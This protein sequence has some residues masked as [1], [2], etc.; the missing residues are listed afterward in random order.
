M[1][2]GLSCGSIPGRFW[3]DFDFQM[4]L[5]WDPKCSQNGIKHQSKINIGFLFDFWS[6][7]V[8]MVH[9]D[10]AARNINVGGG[11]PPKHLAKFKSDMNMFT[12]TWSLVD[13]LKSDNL[14][15]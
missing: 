11:T 1:A 15:S 3:A 13:K 8:G 4:E 10:R 6:S 2:L 7:Q 5:N 14:I 9:M 12:C